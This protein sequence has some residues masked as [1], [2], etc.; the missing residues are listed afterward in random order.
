MYYLGLSA[1]A[2][3]CKDISRREKE[4]GDKRRGREKDEVKRGSSKSALGQRFLL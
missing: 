4:R 2:G 1:S 3:K